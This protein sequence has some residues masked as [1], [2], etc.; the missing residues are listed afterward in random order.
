MKL[1]SYLE[2]QIALQLAQARRSNF[3]EANIHRNEAILTDFVH[4]MD[5]GDMEVSIPA[6]VEDE[7]R[8]LARVRVTTSLLCGLLQLPLTTKIIQVNGAVVF[9]GI[10]EMTVEDVGLLPVKTGEEIPLVEPRESIVHCQFNWGQKPE[11]PPNKNLR[12]NE[13]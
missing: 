10:V 2:R 5:D 9:D 4:S 6:K 8:R 1:R 11:P 12:E 13:Y 7:K 3:D